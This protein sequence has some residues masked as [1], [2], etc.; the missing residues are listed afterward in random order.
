M[1]HDT[2]D[3]GQPV[4]Q[5]LP[6][7]QP[8]PVPPRSP[9]EGRTCRLEP[10]SAEAHAADLHAA[11]ALDQQGQMWTYMAY[12]P[13]ETAESY[14]AWC[15]EKSRLADPLFFAIVDRQTGQAVGVASYLRID[16]RSGSIE[17]G[18]LTYSPQLQ[19]TA[20]ATEAM[21]L[22]MRQAFDLGYRRY[23]WKC[24]ALNAASR[25]AALRLGFAF[26][27][28]F[29]QAAVVKGRNRDTAW[30]SI[31]DQRVARAAASL[32]AMAR[33]REFRRARPAARA[34]LG[35]DSDLPKSATLTRSVSEGLAKR[36]RGTS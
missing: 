20:I 5:L 16:P 14:R 33:S 10:L 19:R 9:L 15:E 32:P 17:V 35:I 3:L 6:D 21:F 36:Q 31:I 23:E 26:E 8:P 1:Q 7:W 29:R 2:N 18:H 13:F 12:G 30:Y 24:H 27:G 22:M 34:A 28:I 4:G 25:A 11:F